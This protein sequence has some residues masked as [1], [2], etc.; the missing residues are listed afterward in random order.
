MLRGPHAFSLQRLLSYYRG[1]LRNEVGRGSGADASCATS[2]ARAPSG[3]VGGGGGGT[4]AGK[5]SLLAWDG[6]RAT[7]LLAPSAAGVLVQ[8]ASFVS[9]RLLS[10]VSTL[11][12]AGCCWVA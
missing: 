7:E 9:L 11:V 8:V 10:L 2:G 4:P 12:L 5:G 6:D 1:L 3:L